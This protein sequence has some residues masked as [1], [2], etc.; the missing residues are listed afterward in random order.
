MRDPDPAASQRTGPSPACGESVPTQRSGSS[1]CG[2]RSINRAPAVSAVGDGKPQ[3]LHPSSEPRLG[4]GTRTSSARPRP[5][6]PGQPQP[7][8]S[9]CWRPGGS[10]NTAPPGGIHTQAPPL[11]S[12]SP[13]PYMLGAQRSPTGDPHFV[14]FR[15]SPGALSPRLYPSLGV[16]PRRADRQTDAL[17]DRS[18]LPSCVSTLMNPNSL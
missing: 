4:T 8:P 18:H 14:K 11:G 1:S 15:V 7:H 3:N 17:L 16:S 5:W 9:P 13:T 10:R 12:D 2:Q 6:S